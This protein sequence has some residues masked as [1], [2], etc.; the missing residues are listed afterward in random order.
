MKAVISQS[1]YFP[2]VGLLEQVQLADVFIHYDDVQYTRGFYNRV[3]IKT[4]HGSKWMTVPLRDRHQG[5]NINEIQIDNRTDWRSQ[6]RNILKHSYL[7]APYRDEMLSLVDQVFSKNVDTLSDISRESIYALTN[8]FG[9]NERTFFMSSADMGIMGSSSQRLCNLCLAVSADSYI[10]GHGA[11]NYLN[12][13]LFE[14]FGINVEYVNYRMA[15]YPQLHGEFNPY[16]T[17]LDLVA[18]CG[19]EGVHFICS[20]SLNWKEFMNEPN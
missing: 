10:T 1:M 19:Q 8:Y 18:N 12:H 5:Q 16:V 3:Q 11:L 13:E 17:G 20:N 15:P 2:W 6:Q 9:L 14:K 4:A 7:H